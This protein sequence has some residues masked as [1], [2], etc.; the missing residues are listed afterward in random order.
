MAFLGL[1]AMPDPAGGML[2]FDA[3][4]GEVALFHPSPDVLVFVDPGATPEV[5]VRCPVA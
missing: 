5:H 4:R 1:D 2:R 3:M